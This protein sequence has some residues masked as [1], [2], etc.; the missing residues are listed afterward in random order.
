MKGFLVLIFRIVLVSILIFGLLML[1]IMLINLIENGVLRIIIVCISVFLLISVQFIYLVARISY[2][3]NDH[4]RKL[5][6]KCKILESK[7]N[8]LLFGF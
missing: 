7:I 3:Y 5:I 6:N 4:D 2:S 1:N 8:N